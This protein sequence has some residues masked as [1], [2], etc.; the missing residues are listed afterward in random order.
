MLTLLDTIV[1]DGVNVKGYF[2]WSLLDNFEWADGYNVRFGITY[3]DYA[4][5]LTRY[6]KESYYL[7]QSLINYLRSNNYNRIT[8][9]SSF[10]LIRR[11]K[12]LGK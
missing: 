8:M 12:L 7:Y 4:N 6:P 5:N 3:V 11:S 10:E 9:P 1:E 2:L